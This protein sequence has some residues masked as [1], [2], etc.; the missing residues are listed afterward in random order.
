M[1]KFISKKYVDSAVVQKEIIKRLMDRLSFINFVPRK[2][3]DLG[4]GV[5]L[6]TESL[7]KIHSSAE[8]FMVDHSFDSLNF[9]ILSDKNVTPVCANF[10]NIPFEADLFTWH[11]EDI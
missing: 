10:K 8:F 7:M 5:G 11:N 9:N 3:L 1:S 2:I 4:S 6:R